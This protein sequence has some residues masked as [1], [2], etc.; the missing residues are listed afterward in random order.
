MFGPGATFLVLSGGSCHGCW[1]GCF[2]LVIKEFFG[3]LELSWCQDIFERL[4]VS[5]YLCFGV[6]VLVVE[7]LEDQACQVFFTLLYNVL[8]F[9]FKCLIPVWWEATS[10]VDLIGVFFLPN[11]G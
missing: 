4:Q 11:S 2:V 1:Y 3:L 9:R 6:L 7:V 5:L 8:P 10:K